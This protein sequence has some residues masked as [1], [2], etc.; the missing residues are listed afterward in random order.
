[1]G[2]AGVLVHAQLGILVGFDKGAHF[3]NVLSS[4]GTLY[5]GKMGSVTRMRVVSY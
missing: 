4:V 2:F 1:L 5:I 3:G